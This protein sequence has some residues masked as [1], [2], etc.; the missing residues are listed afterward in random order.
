MVRRLRRAH[1]ADLLVFHALTKSLEDVQGGNLTAADGGAEGPPY[2]RRGLEC[3][4]C[5]AN[6]L[7]LLRFFLAVGRVDI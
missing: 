2:S 6:N 5:L 7:Q 3:L 1:P 4:D